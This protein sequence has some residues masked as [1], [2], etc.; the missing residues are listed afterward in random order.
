MAIQGVDVSFYQGDVD[1]QAV[2]NDGIVFA[3]AKATE[4]DYLVD[5]KF[6]S[7]WTGMRAAGIIRGA[8]H[9]FRPS[10][11][12]QVQANFF[13][14]TINKLESDDLPPVCDIEVTSGVDTNTI[15][16]RLS[17]W[18][19][20]V[21]KGLGRKPI[22]YTAPNFWQSDLGDIQLFSDYPLWIAHYDTNDPI[23][24][25]AWSTWIFHQYSE[26][27]TVQGI[28]GNADL[29]RFESFRQGISGEYIKDFQKLLQAKGFY[30][31]AI[32]GNFGSVMN[33]AVIAFQQAVG[34]DAD[35]VIGLRTWNALTGS[36]KATPTPKPPTPTPTP[37]PKPPT[38]TPTP[39]PKP[40]TPTPTPTPKPPTPTP[41][42]TP[43]PPTPTPTSAVSLIN[44]CKFYSALPHQDQ[45]LQWLQGQIPKATLDEFGRRWRNLT[46]PKPP[47]ISL[48]E[49]GKYYQSLANQDLSL[50]WLQGQIPKATL[51]E[52]SQRW[53]S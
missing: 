31:G 21:E 24:P 47:T 17:Q 52:F 53:K 32:D 10:I 38:P 3:F 45:A 6:T 18:L 27:G 16:D 34:L 42:P 29:D 1:W 13:I 28:D 39:T 30:A 51:D 20:A 49:V 22:I 36:V 15:V 37:T 43:K 44:V 40:P 46:S 26:S 4:G 50:Q 5:S 35:G 12:P 9:F 25:G 33:T 19:N 2:A 7:Y 23:V 14:Q 48:L 41:T 8:Y 11:D